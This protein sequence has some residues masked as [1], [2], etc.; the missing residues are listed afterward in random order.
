MMAQSIPIQALGMGITI[1]G[2]ANAAK[3]SVRNGFELFLNGS[4]ERDTKVIDAKTNTND[5]Q[6]KSINNTDTSLSTNQNNS[7][8]QADSNGSDIQTN[9]VM[10]NDEQKADDLD[11]NSLAEGILIMLNQIREVIIKALDL[12]PEE[13]DVM[14]KDMGLE[15]SDLADP[16]VIMQ[17]VL[18]NNGQTDPFVM[19][20]DEQLGDTFQSLIAAVNEIKDQTNLKLTDDEFKLILEQSTVIKDSDAADGGDEIKMQQYAAGSEQPK[21]T[22]EDDEDGSKV[23]RF[24]KVSEDSGTSEQRTVVTSKSD[25]GLKDTN[26]GESKSD[27]SGESGFEVFLDR[28]DAHYDKPIIEFTDDN[29]SLYDIRE[30]AQQI[31]EQIRVVINPEQTS[32]ELQLYPEHLGKVNLTVSSRDGVMTAHFTVQNEIAKEAV[33][34]QLIML[35]DTLAQQG[36]KVESIE[37]TVASYTFD[38]ESHSDDANQHMNKKQRSGHRIT[39]E[40]AVTMS[41]EPLEKADAILAGTAG[42]TIDYTA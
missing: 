32:M 39:F 16:Q 9:K 2:P 27:K 41:E 5:T 10:S 25:Q 8:M 14:M 13:L 26:D 6:T 15:L 11:Y 42:Y 24:Q 33:E 1:R 23:I 38:Q 36:I 31:I 12:T 34:G 7:I 22:K 30:I 28:L 20:V 19:L 18:A 17:L 21:D 40:E 29:V 35:K 4:I 3:G 37:V